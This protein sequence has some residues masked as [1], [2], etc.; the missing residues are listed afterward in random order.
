MTTIS[1]SRKTL[2]VLFAA[3][4]VSMTSLAFA[5]TAPTAPDTAPPATPPA[6]MHDDPM[7]EGAA[8]P[9]PNTTSAPMASTSKPKTFKDLDAN[10][11][12]KLSK[13]EVAGDPTWSADFDAADTNKDGY[14]SKSEFKKHEADLK[15]VASNDSQ[16]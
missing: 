11:D 4:A 13:D 15:K 7:Q 9:A 10:K 14:I 1:L 6:A 12:G 3:S 8:A 16:K 5:Q 2:L